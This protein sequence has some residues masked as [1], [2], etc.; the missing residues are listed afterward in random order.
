MHINGVT[1]YDE[2][3]LPHGG[4][5]ASGFGRFGGSWGIEEFLVTKS[6]TFVN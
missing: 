6:I 2:P 5:K 4:V 1:V 3:T